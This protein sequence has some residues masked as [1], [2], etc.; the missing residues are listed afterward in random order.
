MTDSPANEKGRVDL[1]TPP[2]LPPS[3]AP[4]KRSLVDAERDRGSAVPSSPYTM[5]VEGMASVEKGVRLLSAGLPALA[6][7]MQELLVNLQQVVPKAMADLQAGIPGAAG[8]P[9]VVAAAPPP[10][11]AGPPAA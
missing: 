5:A 10:P 4:A 1:N 2:P 11:A 7:A 8:A 3:S 6:P 9:G